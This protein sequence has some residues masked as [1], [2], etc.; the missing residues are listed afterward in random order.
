MPFYCGK[1]IASRNNRSPQYYSQSR[2]RLT[3][4]NYGFQMYVD[5]KDFMVSQTIIMTG[6]W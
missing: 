5:A 6:T 1:T 4:T 3:N 2:L